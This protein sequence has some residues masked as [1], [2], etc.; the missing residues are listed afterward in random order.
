MGP[1]A[2]LNAVK[3]RKFLAPAGNRTPAIQ[4]VSSHYTDR[5]IIIIILN[6]IVG[7][8]PMC[9][10]PDLAPKAIA[11]CKIHQKLNYTLR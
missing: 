9:R 8:L 6:Y 7:I 10:G 4:P 3:R 5:A 1:T 2:G 11:S